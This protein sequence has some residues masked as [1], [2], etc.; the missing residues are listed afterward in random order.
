MLDF[1]DSRPI[2]Q[3]Y[4]VTNV[5]GRLGN[6]MFQIAAAV[7][8]AQE[9]NKTV[10]IGG[11]LKTFERVFNVRFNRYDQNDACLFPAM[12]PARRKAV[13]ATLHGGGGVIF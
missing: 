13:S 2:E 6:Q 11:D 7:A 1:L 8:Y 4:V 3:R 9:Q 5:F 10:V 12:K